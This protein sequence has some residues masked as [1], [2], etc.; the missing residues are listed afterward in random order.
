MKKLAGFVGAAAVL[1]SSMAPVWAQSSA[2]NYVEFY[3]IRENN[4]TDIDWSNDPL[5][6][7]DLQVRLHSFALVGTGGKVGVVWTLSPTPDIGDYRLNNFS[8]EITYRNSFYGAGEKMRP[9][10]VVEYKDGNTVKY[11]TLQEKDFAVRASGAGRTFWEY[12]FKIKQGRPLEVKRIAIG[13]GEVKRPALESIPFDIA[14][15]RPRVAR[16]SPVEPV[17]SYDTTVRVVSNFNLTND[18]L[19]LEKLK[20]VVVS[21]GS[22]ART[23]PNLDRLRENARNRFDNFEDRLNR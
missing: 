13:G 4:S 17:R 23:A 21:T 5:N 11:L 7:G 16:I 8:F 14:V 12:D 9:T 15:Y 10:V 20:G 1:I 19:L 6:A 3:A 2:D 22:N 18:H